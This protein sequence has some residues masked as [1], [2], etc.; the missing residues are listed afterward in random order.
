MLLELPKVD[1]PC[2]KP[3]A[4]L[5]DRFAAELGLDF[6]TAFNITGFFIFWWSL[7]SKR[8]PENPDAALVDLRTWLK[9]GS[10]ERETLDRY[11]AR[12]AISSSDIPT[13]FD[14]SAAESPFLDVLPFR[15]RP[16]LRIDE[17]S[18]AYL[19]PQFMAE[20]GGTDLL[21][22]LA[23]GPGG[24]S[25]SQPFIQDFSSLYE[26]YIRSILEGLGPQKI[27]GV[28]IPNVKWHVGNQSG[29]IDGLIHFGDTLAIMEVKASLLKQTTLSRGSVEEIR[30]ELERKF[31]TGDDSDGP[32]G[33][34][35]I[36]RAI[37][38]L[39]GERKRGQR[40]EGIDL[41]SIKR[42]LP[43]LVVH[44]RTLRFP[45]LG[46]W[47]DGR[48]RNL[49]RK[50]WGRIGPL[51]LC[52]TED[53]ENLEHLALAGREKLSD[54]L[55]EYDRRYMNAE[56]ALWTVYRAPSGLHPRLD[57]IITNW[58]AEIQREGVL[59]LQ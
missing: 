9:R 46:A 42:I 28:Y 29:E 15:A 13:A 34:L 20:K 56:A 48:M 21:W 51:T 49:L 3:A 7:H 5:R 1:P 36:A 53:V 41:R 10:I 6:E 27:G 37:N 24:Q 11:V 44:D 45:G 19:C 25:Q 23:S 55:D 12:V 40:I 50:S 59:P 16:I 35:Q 22:L 57:E 2:A 4:R 38:W 47:F 58:M 30:A 17:H 43:M 52:G 14:K 39:A 18:L 26:R 54:V 32:K 33:V 31:V 8:I